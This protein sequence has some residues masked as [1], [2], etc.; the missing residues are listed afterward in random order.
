MRASEIIGG[1]PSKGH[2]TGCFRALEGR[3]IGPY[4]ILGEIGRGGMGAVYLAVRDDDAFQKTGR[5]QGRARGVRPERRSSALPA[6]AA[7]PRPPRAPQHRAPARRRAR[8]TRAARTSSWSTSR[9]CP[10]TTTATAAALA[11]ARAARSSSAASAR[12]CSTRTSTSSSTATSSPAT[13]WSPRDGVP[14]LLDFGIAKLLGRGGDPT[15]A[16]TAT[17]LPML[18]PAYASPEQ[19]RGEPV[20]TATDVYSLGV[21]LYE[22]LT[23]RRPVRAPSATRCRRSRARSARRSRRA[24]RG[25]AMRRRPRPTRTAA[26]A[27]TST[28]SCSRRC[29]R[30]RRGATPRSRS[31]RDDIAAPPRG[32]A[33]AG[34]RRHARLPRGEVRAP[35]PRRRW[36]RRCSSSLASWAASWPPRAGAHRASAARPRRAA[37]QRRA[38]AGQRVPVRVPRRD[39]GPAG[40]TRRASWWC[41]GPR[42]PGRAGRGGPAATRRCSASWRRRTR[43]SATSREPP[44]LREPRPDPGPPI[45]ATP[46][47][48]SCARPWPRRARGRRGSARAWP[49]RASG[50]ATDAHG[51]G[52]LGRRHAA[53]RTVARRLQFP[54][55]RNAPTTSRPRS[56]RPAAR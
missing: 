16:P 15:S 2:G 40:S 54:W 5:D 50:S 44:G 25:R 11:V 23:G 24:E 18:T 32:P 51:R 7:D 21:V 56:T 35:A 38:R 22:L 36:P 1:L 37:L 42:V 47:P 52:Q 9:A 31:C 30:S 53:V 6:R 55:P 10:S 43:R 8:P 19:V 17:V 13:S 49:W 26:R 28:P 29:A 46:G 3:R 12:R 48:S 45:G 14:K 27:A 34:A 41:G 33:G 20:T 39:R 4:R